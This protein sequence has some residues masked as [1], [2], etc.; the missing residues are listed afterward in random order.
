V[1]DFG[2]ARQQL[3][4]AAV[5]EP[6]VTFAGT[7]GYAAP[8]VIGGGAATPASDV[9]SLGAVGHYLLTGR[10]PFSTP[11]SSTESL[12][13]TLSAP[14]EPLPASVPEA[15]G[16]LLGACLSK[17][18]SDRPSS[19]AQLAERLRAALPTCHPWTRQDADLW[20]REHPREPVSGPV[21]SASA[22]FLPAGRGLEGS[23][24]RRSDTRSR[25]R[26]R[27]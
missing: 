1:L 27:A 18:P 13:R 26:A 9:F 16:R 14:P 20:W 17:S 2:L 5:T 6:S 15:L 19:M 3:G 7:P 4:H 25:S 10:G 22:T 8:E 24:S 11:G 21:T 12:T 23:S